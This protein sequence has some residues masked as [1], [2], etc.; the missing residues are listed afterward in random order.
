MRFQSV[1][2]LTEVF[3]V[4]FSFMSFCLPRRN[5]ST[6]GPGHIGEDHRN[7]NAV[8]DANGIHANLA[9]LKA[10][11]HSLKRGAFED[12]H[13]I[14]ERDAVAGNVTSIL[15][16]VP[17]VVHGIMFTLCIYSRALRKGG[18]SGFFRELQ[19]PDLAQVDRK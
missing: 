14:L 18:P 10:I 5:D 17:S 15:L 1:R 6:L 19:L 7:L 9:V 8:Y 2:S 11:V 16:R 3:P 4:R 13:G 12:L